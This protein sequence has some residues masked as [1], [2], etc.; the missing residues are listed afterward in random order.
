SAEASDVGRRTAARRCGLQVRLGVAADEPAVIVQFGSHSQVRRKYQSGKTAHYS[1]QGPNLGGLVAC[2]G[3]VVALVP[4]TSPMRPGG[5][6]RTMKA[7]IPVVPPTGSH[8]DLPA[9][10]AANSLSPPEK[11]R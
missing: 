7:I 1:S 2:L 10:S 8:R 11:V 9:L 6:A 4:P 5:A 3:R